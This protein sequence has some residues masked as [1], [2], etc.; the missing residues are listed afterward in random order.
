MKGALY[1]TYLAQDVPGDYREKRAFR[2]EDPEIEI[3][4]V[5]DDEAEKRSEAKQKENR[6]F[7][8][9]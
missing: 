6:R 5:G 3:Q 2:E 1:P 9:E 4:N 7:S 8:L